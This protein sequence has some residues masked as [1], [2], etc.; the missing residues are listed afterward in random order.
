MHECRWRV[1]VDK[2]RRRFLSY[3]L[4]N[5]KYPCNKSGK[6][7][8]S[9]FSALV[10]PRRKALGVKWNQ[11]F[12]VVLESELHCHLVPVHCVAAHA[13][14]L[15]VSGP[16]PCCADRP[17]SGQ[18]A[19]KNA[20]R[21]YCRSTFSSSMSSPRL[22]LCLKHLWAV[23]VFYLSSRARQ[24]FGVNIDATRGP[25]QLRLWSVASI[26]GDFRLCWAGVGMAK[27]S[28]RKP[29]RAHSRARPCD[30]R[31]SPHV[32]GDSWRSHGAPRSSATSMTTKA[33]TNAGRN[34]VS[35][36]VYEM[37]EEKGDLGRGAASSRALEVGVRA[38]WIRYG[39]REP[40]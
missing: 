8:P 17:A 38:L 27:P 2:S 14:G 4:A 34:G 3:L 13:A 35:L 29:T 25:G 7:L 30:T 11:V 6:R 16:K 37:P 39:N 26:G 31:R 10:L 18:S 12:S 33:D 28:E 20:C 23:P 22:C 32:R 19:A 1:D 9:N 40:F 36:I 5:A 21:A 24:Q 15:A